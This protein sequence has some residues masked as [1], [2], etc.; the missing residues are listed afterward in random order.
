M[1][2]LL[3]RFGW[4]F[5][6]LRSNAQPQKRP[7]SNAA[8]LDAIFHLSRG[9]IPKGNLD[10]VL[11]Q[12]KPFNSVESPANVI[13]SPSNESTKLQSMLSSMTK[14]ENQ[15]D[16]LFDR[17]DIYPSLI[18]KI[19]VESSLFK[20]S[21]ASLDKYLTF[22]FNSILSQLY[23][24][25]PSNYHGT[26]YLTWAYSSDQFDYLNYK[27]FE[28]LFLLYPMADFVIF[29]IAPASSDYY[30][31]GK[32]L[33]KTTFQKYTRR[34]SNVRVEMIHNHHPRGPFLL[35]KDNH[36]SQFYS[37]KMKF[38]GKIAHPS[39]SNNSILGETIDQYWKKHFNSFCETKHINFVREKLPAPYHLQLYYVMMKLYETGGIFTDFTFLH[40]FSV[41]HLLKMKENEILPKELETGREEK[42]YEGYYFKTI[43]HFTA[44]ETMKRGRKKRQPQEQQG[45]NGKEPLQEQMDC[46]TS[47]L[48]A[49]SAFHPILYCVLSHF[50]EKIDPMFSKCLK[51][52]RSGAGVYCIEFALKNCF[53]KFNYENPFQNE[54]V[55]QQEYEKYLKTYHPKNNS[56]NNNIVNSNNINSSGRKISLLQLLSHKSC[57]HV[58]SSTS[59]LESP[60]LVHILSHSE[61]HEYQE[62]AQ[63]PF[64]YNEFL[65]GDLLTSVKRFHE[66]KQQLLDD[67]HLVPK[68]IFPLIWFGFAAYSNDWIIPSTNSF[69]GQ[70]I[71]HNN[72]LFRALPATSLALVSSFSSS[73]ATPSGGHFHYPLATTDST[74]SYPSSLKQRANLSSS[75]S[76]VIPGFMKA[77][78]TYFY[79]AISR[80]PLIVKALS[81]VNFKET[82]CYLDLSS[83]AGSDDRK[84]SLSIEEIDTQLPILAKKK[85]KLMNCFPFI[86]KGFDSFVYGDA[87]V[88]YSVRETVPYHLYQD[89]PNLKIIFSL[90]NPI[91]RTLSH[92]RFT[93][94]H[95]KNHGMGNINDCLMFVLNDSKQI[96]WNWYSIAVEL[97]KEKKDSPKRELLRKKLLTEY[98]RG[99]GNKG[100]ESK[101]NG[102]LYNRCGHLL[103]YSLYFMPIYHWYQ[104]FPKENIRLLNIHY[105]QP[106][107][108]SNEEKKKLMN[109]GKPAVHY[110]DWTAL[111]S[112]DS[113]PPLSVESFKQQEMR[114]EASKKDA[115]LFLQRYSTEDQE[116]MLYQMNEIYK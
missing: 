36:Q 19:D 102:N 59:S 79:D 37:Q 42:E 99:M 61:D 110:M 70:W 10:Y 93:Y 60:S 25:K 8:A 96:F 2:S 28:S 33:S 105:L 30:K 63:Y 23:T 85:F 100:Q 72:Q 62:C 4:F 111:F 40:Q 75:L 106:F 86:E 11:A 17:E 64:H 95:L 32:I 94:T 53:R 18:K 71:A 26:V 29:L 77:G 56:N 114:K 98:F 67:F 45:E 112:Y 81:G 16:L 73:A 6:L 97:L 27:S 49:F 76:F 87:T 83:V 1:L 39:S 13:V 65:F 115:N 89:N 38:T 57:Y 22:P 74:Y 84:E 54:L 24:S 91:E 41:F 50:H 46:Q 3:F 51:L 82:G 43:C 47:S 101:S 107:H 88:Y 7:D 15:K 52:D 108:F 48:L 14:C 90:R 113:V 69:L 68:P 66:Q 80:H 44:G 20:T 55:V 109:S 104:I 116:Y 21:T 12:E 92:H 35:S 103:L 9:N 31:V 5:V 78:T 34:F 58:L